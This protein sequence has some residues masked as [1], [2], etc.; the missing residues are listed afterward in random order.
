MRRS[1]M[2]T[3]TFDK[4]S[5][6]RGGFTI[7]DMSFTI[8]EGY[9]TGLIGPNGSCKTSAIQMMMDIV[10]PDEGN[11][12]IYGHSYKNHQTKQH[13]G[14]VYD[15]LYMYDDFTIKKMKAFIAPLYKD[16]N[17]GLFNH[18]LEQFDLPYKKK[19]KKLSKGMKMKCS[20]LFALAHEPDFLIMD[21]P[22]AGLDPI[23]RR[24]L[25]GL[26]QDLMQNDRQTIFLSTHI[27]TDLDQISD[28][29]V[30][31]HKGRFCLRF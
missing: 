16:W 21:E 27:T 25:L 24:E 11:I 31:I 22:T 29:I 14:F 26:L 28:K 23:F 13:I 3:V 6:K 7:N 17:E 30:L 15:D 5:K 4:V 2:N 1:N 8:P 10:Q 9:I 20:L 19:L 18:Y 12:E